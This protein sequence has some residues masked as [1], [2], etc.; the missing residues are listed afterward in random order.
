MTLPKQALTPG[1]AA[2]EEADRQLQS[3]EP[4]EAIV[5]DYDAIAA[6]TI[7]A[8]RQQ[9]NARVFGAISADTPPT[10]NKDEREH[11]ARRATYFGP[12]LQGAVADM[13][14]GERAAAGKAEYERGRAEWRQVSEACPTCR[15]LLEHC[16]EWEAQWRSLQSS[17]ERLSAAAREGKH[18]LCWG[19]TADERL[20]A[21]RAIE[22]ALAETEEKK[23]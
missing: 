8:A 12:A 5:L 3:G 7:E 1:Q 19:H 13:L 20:E 10:E 2:R 11:C 15:G 18:K 21:A 23:T 9:Q 16:S 14:E 17:Y 22:A 4:G 6:A